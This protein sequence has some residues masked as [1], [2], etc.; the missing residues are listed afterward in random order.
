[1]ISSYTCSIF[2]SDSHQFKSSYQYANFQF[3][4][5]YIQQ[6][7]RQKPLCKTTKY[8]KMACLSLYR[9]NWAIINSGK[10]KS[11]RM[12]GW[13]HV[14]E[15]FHFPSE[16]YIRERTLEAPNR[17]W[18][19][20]NVPLL[21][22][23]SSECVIPR[24]HH[25]KTPLNCSP[26]NNDRSLQTPDHMQ[27]STDSKCQ[28]VTQVPILP[29]LEESYVTKSTSTVGSSQNQFKR[30][31]PKKKNRDHIVPIDS[32]SRNRGFGYQAVS[33]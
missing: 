13:Q 20:S 16:S 10:K 26:T 29:R 22:S 17:W 3:K 28:Q 23:C 32:M 11:V 2:I 30:Q 27:C 4:I 21:C 24:N 6:C 25:K 5:C 15:A 18:S 33:I 12:A 14:V 8:I 7:S 19:T 1:M 31:S 9:R